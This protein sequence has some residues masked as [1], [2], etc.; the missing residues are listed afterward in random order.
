MIQAWDKEVDVLVVGSGAGG[1]L[2]ALVAASNH[3][4]VLIIEK[5]KLWGGT[6]A[7]SGAGIWIPGSD[8]ARASGFEDN[9]DDA[10]KYLRKLSADNVPDANIRL[11]LLGSAMGVLLHQRGLLPLHA[12]AVEIDGKAF[13]FMGAS[14]SGKST[15]AAWFH[16]HGYRIIADDVCAVRF[17]TEGD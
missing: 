8:T 9:L 13:A 16:D 6:S 7:T 2:S 14:G 4:E 3:A 5:D 1:M 10:F 17:E 15:L 12:N 11:Y